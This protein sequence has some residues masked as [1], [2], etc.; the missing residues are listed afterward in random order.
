MKV[1]LFLFLGPKGPQAVCQSTTKHCI[2]ASVKHGGGASIM[3]WGFSSYLVGPKY[4]IQ[5]STDQFA[6]VK[7]LQEITS[8]HA[9]EETPSKW[10]FR[11]D[12]DL[13]NTSEQAASS[14][15]T[16]KIKVMERAS[17]Q[18]L[19]LNPTEHLWTDIEK[20]CCWGEKQE[21]QRNRG[22]LWDQPQAEIPVGPEVPE[23]SG[24]H[25]TQMW[26]TSQKPRLHN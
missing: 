9:E 2:E 22:M 20:C 19:E 5:G 25:A 3:I 8:S 6:H 16:N 17:T 18:C 1:T 23:V 11:Q 13:K 4:R 12:T 24:L 21:M 14:F 7:I 26:S 10:V 15:Q